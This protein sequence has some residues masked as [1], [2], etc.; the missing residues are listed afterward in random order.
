MGAREAILGSARL[1]TLREPWRRRYA[2]RRRLLLWTLGRVLPPAAG[3]PTERLGTGYGGWTVPAGVID[4]SWVCYCAGAG[5]DVSF[6][7]AL[8]ERF[9]CTV[10]TIDPTDES[11]AHVAPF[12]ELRFHQAALWSRD[13][14]LA[15]YRAADPTHQTL[16]ADDLQATGRAVTVSARSLASLRAELGH[17]RVDLLK[18]DVEGA[19][20][21][22]LPGL[23]AESPGLSVVCVEV[24]PTRG[25]RTA[26]RAFRALAAAGFRLAARDGADFTFTR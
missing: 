5:I 17:D 13:G 26:V 3:L 2:L 18:L 19:E 21:E 22:L 4:A 24:H 23:E 14:E 9:G 25:L 15:M 11:R 6:D 12:P 20:W 16:S 10:V 8:V 1:R 7:R